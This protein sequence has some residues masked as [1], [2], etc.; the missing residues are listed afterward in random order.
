MNTNVTE[1][2]VNTKADARAI[3]RERLTNARKSGD[4]EAEAEAKAKLDA[5]KPV[6]RTIAPRSNRR[7]A[8][9]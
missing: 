4:T 5:L 8:A 6:P 3:W 7:F 2:N 9:K 1:L